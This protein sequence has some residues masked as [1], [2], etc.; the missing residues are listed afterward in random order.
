MIRSLL[1]AL[2]FSCLLA[3]CAGSGQNALLG[4]VLSRAMQET[5]LSSADQGL[6]VKAVEVA[7]QSAG[8]RR[9]RAGDISSPAPDNG[10]PAAEDV[11]VW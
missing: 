5:S 7:A 1:S 10:E 11:E 6:A 4:D 2:V 9:E 8:Q 3:G